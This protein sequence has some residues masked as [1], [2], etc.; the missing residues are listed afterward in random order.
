[1]IEEETSLCATGCRLM[2]DKGKAGYVK[3]SVSGVIV[4]RGPRRIQITSPCLSNSGV[5]VP[6][7]VFLSCSY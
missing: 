6:E 2:R 5:G 1:M 4:C 3:K 7:P